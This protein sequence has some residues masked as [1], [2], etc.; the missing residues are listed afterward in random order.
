MLALLSYTASV[1]WGRKH[2]GLHD[3]ENGAVWLWLLVLPVMSMAHCRGPWQLQADM[4]R[5]QCY[6]NGI[7][8]KLIQPEAASLTNGIS[9]PGWQ[10]LP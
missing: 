6:N 5:D 7:Y 1:W 2:G 4:C 8:L 9:V 10:P 3:P